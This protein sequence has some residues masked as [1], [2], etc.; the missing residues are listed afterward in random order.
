MPP[1]LLGKT[2]L[3][4]YR[5][6]EFIAYTPLGEL[7]RAT[8]IRRD[9]SFALTH[10]PGTISE[11]IE[12]LKELETEWPR[13]REVTHPNLTPYLGIFQ[14]PTLA[15]VLEEWTDGPSLVEILDK[16]PVSV[17]EAL[18]YLKVLCSALEALH[19]QGYLHLNLAP[20]LIRVNK[21]GSIRLSGLALA[22]RPGQAFKSH[23]AYPPLY[24]APE[25][26]GTDVL[27]PASDT[28][29]LAVIIYQLI[30]GTW[31][32]GKATPKSA[33]AIRKV[34]LEL[35]PPS[36]LSRQ[37]EIPDHFARMLLW[38]LR[39]NPQDR[40]KTT[41]ELL[42]SLVL[43]ARKSVDVVSLRA[44]ARTAPITWAVLSEWQYLP[45][46]RQNIIL[47]DATPL[48]DRLAALDPEQPKKRRR[49]LGIPPVFLLIMAAGMASLFW[50]VR[51]APV[52]IA[53]PLQFTPFASDY[54]PPPTDTALPRPT[55]EHGGRIAF[56]CTRGDY[57]QVCIVNRDGSGLSQLTDMDASNYYP[58]F[59]RD[60]DGLLFASNREGPFDLYL[61]LFDAEEIA[62]LTDNVG[63]VVSP[64]YS[65][66]GRMIVF[67]NRVGNGTT[68]IWMVNADGLN[69]R[70]VYSGIDDIASV[71]WSPNG[72]KIAYA[73]SNGTPF[74]Y[75]IYTMDANGKNHVHISEGL[76]GIGGSLS[77]SPDSKYLLVYAGPFD[78]KDIFR[79]DASNGDF[80][81]LTDGGN[82]AGASYS[83]DGRYIVF[84]SMRN[85]DQADLYI[86]RSDGTNQVQLTNHPEPDWG[87]QWVN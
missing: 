72:E 1:A 46:P 25:Q 67:A 4:Q 45:P 24:R 87:P 61:L 56:T 38:A 44:D 14:T 79:L 20:Q 78:A 12:A 5:I 83:P 40:L 74:E 65:P 71:A 18:V 58:T 28:Y 3:N 70:L 19:Q 26:F 39:K 51:P 52:M 55:S 6:E 11:S 29:A 13:L 86:M 27:T 35:A 64:D 41:T 75:E 82:N 50:I 34:H 16:G 85:N 42:T 15:F 33:D 8:D 73:M 37:R 53:T 60:G 47:Q 49:R 57:N 66:D 76:R 23:N 54:T 80:I 63:N 48:Q 17:D 68:A 21:Q 84:N 9:R 81:Q 59:T 43:G 10:L 69:A 31:I 7:Y 30:T 77:W 62:R 22:R 32:N 36:P 2:L